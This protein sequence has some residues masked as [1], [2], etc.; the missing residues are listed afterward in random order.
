MPYQCPQCG[1]EY[2][3]E[4]SCRDRFDRCLALEYENPTAWGA[5]HHLTVV[6]YM[7]HHIASSRRAWLEAR[8]MLA[9][10]VH[11]GVTPAAIL[12]HNRSRLDRTHRTWNVTK[13][14]KL[15]EFAVLIWSRTIAG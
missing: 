14:E 5:V 15:P 12:A 1:A 11:A 4:D 13:G 8:K 9:Q 6:C 3:A 2:P 10:F 7:L